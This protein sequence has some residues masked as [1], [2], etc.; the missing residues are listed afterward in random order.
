[1]V[2]MATVSFAAEQSSNRRISQLIRG[3]NFVHRSPSER[4]PTAS[5]LNCPRPTFEFYRPSIP[6]S[7]L[8]VYGIRFSLTT[9]YG[10]QQQ[11]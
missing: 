1:M 9:N 3:Q 8:Q 2:G 7:K 10:N 11:P 5:W 4:F 6:F